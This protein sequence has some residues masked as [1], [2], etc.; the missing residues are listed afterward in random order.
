MKKT[1]L[2]LT[3]GLALVLACSAGFAG[4][5]AREYELS[6]YRGETKDADGNTV[7]N[8]ELFYS[9]QV[10]Q[11]YPD[12][13]VLDDM[14]RSGYYYLFGTW[15]SFTTMRSKDLVNW[16]DVGPTFLQRQSEDVRRAT[17]SN[18]WAPEVIYDEDTE[19]YYMF[20]SAT[21]EA[22]STYTDAKAGQGVVANSHMYNMYV[23][24]SSDPAGP[25]TMVDFSRKENCHLFEQEDGSYKGRVHNGYNTERGKVLSDM[26]AEDELTGKYAYVEENGVY[27]EAAFPHY[28]AKFCL[29]APDE[30]YK[31]NDKLGITQSGE[32]RTCGLIWGSGYFGNIDPHPYV[33]PVTGE[34]YLY[35][36]LSRPTGIL[37][38]HMFDWL[39][40]DWD[41]VEL[42]S[43][44]NYYT[45]EDW[46]N[47]EN[48]GVS[49]ET[50]DCNEGPHVI[51]H[52]SATQ[53]E[54]EG[55]YYVTFSV[56][57][58][59]TSAYSV[60]TAV[61]DSPMGPFRKLTEEEGG[62]LL[63]SLTLESQSVSGAG[64]HS[65]A[66]LGDQTF[67]IYHRHNDYIA[68]GSARYTATDELKWIT[69]KDI[70]DEMIDVPYT[71][72]PTDSMQP[73]PEAA[74]GYENVAEGMTATCSD[75][76]VQDI[77]CAT[78]GLLSVHKT[79]NATFMD[80][81]RETYITETA[82]FTFD[83]SEATSIRAIMVY[84]SA[85]ESSIFYNISEIEL[86]L[87]DGGTRV[88]R[89]IAFDTE[90]YCQFGGQNGD[91]LLYVKSGTAAFAEFYDIEVT[92][93]KITVDV[94]EGQDRVGI[95]EIRIL[96]KA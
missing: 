96:G 39:T 61:S 51:Y 89:D 76:S 59:G 35:C 23:A 94:P 93:V 58:Y 27:Y 44:G 81:I 55:T 79:A 95:S 83:F 66:T 38:V 65:F 57:D 63:R 29:F 46:R 25:Y 54:G 49:Y 2:L 80:Y 28:Y 67:V 18:L 33:D 21:P 86:T 19:L 36:N 6:S 77:A 50:A 87:A 60:A 64:H 41:N 31:A 16:E 30:L 43:M 12:P 78:D 69:V 48:E 71:N 5:G 13:Q 72:G 53:A 8:T 84:N 3:A 15:N 52:E 91:R 85:F 26:T 47:D 75:E 7:Y 40:P 34:K 10:Q 20:F 45:V 62:L 82:T 74:S 42:V 14:E 37:V 24:T 73:L 11:G 32:A 9:N 90:Q 68:G 4:C 56:N 88:M 17:A 92:S 1:K 22:D 70:N